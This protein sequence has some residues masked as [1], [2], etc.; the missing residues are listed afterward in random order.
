MTTDGRRLAR[1]ARHDGV[2][3]LILDRA[4][5]RNAIV[6]P[7]VDDL[8]SGLEELTSDPDVRAILLRGE[9]GVLSAGLDVEAF[10][11]DAEPPPWRATFSRRWAEL[12]ALLYECEKPIV[13][14]L[15]TCAIA[16]GSALALACDF[17]VAERDAV[18][19][20]LEVERGMV[21][22]VNIVWL[23]TR[24]GPARALDLALGARRHDGADLLR[25][26]IATQIT[27]RGAALEAA[28]TMATRLAGFA[29][30]PM[31]R[32]KAVSR[33]LSAVDFRRALATAQQRP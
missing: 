21:A 32:T 15:E 11:G 22:P 8:I 17:L 1:I 3:E 25:L 31:A 24:F 12:H 6:G 23:H 13:G 5:R 20:V 10:F 9:G 18:L 16:A 26:G 19:H 30:G 4:E 2:G 33:A 29:P 27:E 28:Q 7:M 14:A